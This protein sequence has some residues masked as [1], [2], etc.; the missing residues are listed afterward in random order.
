MGYYLNNASLLGT[1]YID[2][3]VGIF[4]GDF[5]RN[6]V[7]EV[8]SVYTPSAVDQYTLSSQLG[9]GTSG[10]FTRILDTTYVKIMI[11]GQGRGIL[12][13]QSSGPST[14]AF[15]L[16][17]APN[18]GSAYTFGTYD[19]AFIPG[20]PHESG[21][22]SVDND[23]YKIGGWNNGLMG[24]ETNGTTYSWYIPAK[25]LVVVLLGD[26]TAGHA[27]FQYKFYPDTPKIIYIC[28]DYF[29]TT[30]STRFITAVRGGDV[31]FGGFT[32][33]N[34]RG[35]TVA[36]T[37][38]PITDYVRS[39]A[40]DGS[41]RSLGVYCPGNSYTHNVSIISNWGAS[42]PSNILV[43]NN[44]LSNSADHAIY[45]AWNAGNILSGQRARFQSYYLLGSSATDCDNQLL[46]LRQG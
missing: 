5:A 33:N 44:I 34:S 41:G 14:N 28:M 20:T 38:Y 43:E 32:T 6:T 31:D 39:T 45:C 11:H 21:F 22:I 27:V 2:Q 15:Q 12:G 19:D 36:G 29:N 40:M 42:T 24:Q 8:F 37:N 16:L 25:N 46:L 23:T 3:K 9:P 7:E 30:S 1:G 35:T 17:F 18:G 26:L 13:N 4:D 10:A